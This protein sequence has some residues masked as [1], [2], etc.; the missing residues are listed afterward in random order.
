MKYK[1]PKLYIDRCPLFDIENNI[2]FILKTKCKYSGHY[3]DQKD[4]VCDNLLNAY[5]K[6]KQDAKKG[7]K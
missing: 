4:N 1:P 7:E 3:D 5:L 2:C 6:G